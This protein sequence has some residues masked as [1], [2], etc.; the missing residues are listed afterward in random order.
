MKKLLLVAAATFVVAASAAWEH[1]ASVRVADWTT[2]TKTTVKL[3]ELTGNQMVSGLVAGFFADPP[4]AKFF[5]PMRADSSALLPLFL[6]AAAI[7]KDPTKVDSAEFAVVYPMSISKAD[8]LKLH[9]GTVE[10]NGLLLVKGSFV[11]EDVMDVDLVK[12]DD[13]DANSAA[14]SE[15]KYT[16][17]A[18]TPDGKWAVASDKPDQ[19]KMA[20]EVVPAAA[21]P[22]CGN[23]VQVCITQKGVVMLRKLVAIRAEEAKKNK[24]MFD[25]RVVDILAGI[26][27]CK[28]GIGIGDNGL[29]LNLSSKGIPGTELAKV[30][31]KPLPA[32]PFAFAGPDAIGADSDAALVKADAVAVW[33]ALSAA[34]KLNG[35]DISSFISAA[36][37]NGVAVQK[38]DT[39]ALVKYIP[40]FTTNQMAKVDTEKLTYDLKEAVS[41]LEVPF[42]AAETAQNTTLC[43]VGYKPKFTASARFAATFPE[44]KGKKLFN[45]NVG[46]LAAIVQ[47]I[48]PHVM[49]AIPETERAQ[50]QPILAFLPQESAGGIAAMG[51]R[52]GDALHYTVRISAD[53]LKGISTA[54]SGIMAFTMAKEMQEE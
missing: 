9:P 43:M 31:L 13:D 52:E 4:G 11:P 8:F 46:S 45:A 14:D 41:S 20:L 24:E 1:V 17:V 5:G 48:Q 50:A 23:V 30:G 36:M 2:I 22:L 12:D 25:G 47:S 40:D 49:S 3:G 16:Y 42:K 26:E 33:K 6:D 28:F 44:S 53:E 35:I 27:C 38:F 19:V 7:E 18:I 39:A 29:D 54:V 34:L 51:W 37:V 15:P 10:T 21:K 32:D